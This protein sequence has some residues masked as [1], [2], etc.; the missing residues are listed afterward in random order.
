MA[1]KQLMFCAQLR[2]R[3]ESGEIHDEKDFE[4]A[5]EDVLSRGERR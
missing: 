2:Q 4:E 1:K 3:Y 5:M